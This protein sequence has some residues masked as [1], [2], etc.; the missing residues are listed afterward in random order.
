MSQIRGKDHEGDLVLF[1]LDHACGWF[2]TILQKDDTP[3]LDVSSMFGGLSR[4]GL[5]QLLNR[6][7]CDEDLKRL[8]PQIAA[9]AMDLDPGDV[10]EK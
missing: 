6:H 1:G 10:T 7:L 8:Q 5:V 2:I 3:K 4:G 9:V